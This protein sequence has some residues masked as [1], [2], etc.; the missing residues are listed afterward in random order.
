MRKILAVAVLMVGLVAAATSADVVPLIAGQHSDVGSVTV[1]TN[2]VDLFVEYTTTGGWQLEETHLYV[3]TEPP[4]KSAPGRFPYKHEALG[5]ATSDSYQISWGGYGGG[6]GY[7]LY[8][9]CHAV[10]VNSEGGKDEETAW[11]EGELIGKNWAMYFAVT[12]PECGGTD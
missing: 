7:T 9:A 10:V 5:G 2:G 3:G 6:C 11:G 1:Y 12:L 8:I 4:T